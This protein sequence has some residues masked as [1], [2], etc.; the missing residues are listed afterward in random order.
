MAVARITAWQT[1]T[2]QAYAKKTEAYHEE[3]V[4]L[5]RTRGDANNKGINTSAFD[6]AI[7]IQEELVN[8]L[9]E[10]KS[11]LSPT[12]KQDQIIREE[13]N[14]LLDGANTWLEAAQ[15]LKVEMDKESQL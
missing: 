12:G 14:K 8:A 13:L 9:K 11:G 2:G 1:S 4:H 6:E 15:K 5:L 7:A 3:M 10:M